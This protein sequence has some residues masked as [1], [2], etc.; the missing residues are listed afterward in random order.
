MATDTKT[1]TIEKGE[2]RRKKFRFPIHR[3]L[4]YKLIDEGV[5]VGTGTG[6]SV[7]IG[8]GGVAISLDREVKSGTLIELSISWPVLLDDS[9][10][11]R[12]VAFG[13]VLRS[14]GRKTACTID[15]YEFRT[16]ARSCQAAPAIRNDSMLQRWADGLR[17]EN[18]KTHVATA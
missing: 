3:E 10:P 14:V 18:V 9:C 12:F 17:K 7:N 6:Q 2:D 11:M 8:S 15:K 4:R 1:K 16:Q 13:R 5:L